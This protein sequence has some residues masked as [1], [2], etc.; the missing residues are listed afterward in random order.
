[1]SSEIGEV[2]S[3]EVTVNILVNDQ[4][5]HPSSSPPLYVR[6]SVCPDYSTCVTDVTDVVNFC[7]RNSG[8]CVC[9]VNSTFVDP[10]LSVDLVC[11]RKLNLCGGSEMSHCN[12]CPIVTDVT[13][14]VN[15]CNRN[16][17]ERP[18]GAP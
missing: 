1:M 9:P 15:F 16:S 11:P 12:G 14:V 7:N 4:R 8:R 5:E 10:L 13:D 17:G 3:P 18:T 2:E 6:A